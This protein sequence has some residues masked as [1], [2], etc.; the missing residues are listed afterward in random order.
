M[1]IDA[2]NRIMFFLSFFLCR[3]MLPSMLRHV[4]DPVRNPT[5]PKKVKIAVR[6]LPASREHSSAYNLIPHN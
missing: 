4:V 3:E 1:T 6:L 2:F 5:S